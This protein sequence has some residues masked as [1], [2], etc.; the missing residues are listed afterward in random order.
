[1]KIGISGASGHLGKATVAELRRRAPEHQLVAISRTP[2]SETG[3]EARHGDYNDRAGLVAAYRGLDAVMLIPVPGGRGAQFR[4]AIDAAV[5]AGVGHILLLST[6]GTREAAEPSMFAAYWEGEQHLI[7]TAPRWTILRMNYYA[8]SFAQTAPMSAA[9]GALVGLGDGRVAFVSRDDVA[10]AAAGIL[11]GLGQ[12]GAIYNATG[13]TAYDGAARAAA[14]AQAAGK[15]VAFHVL[16]PAALREQLQAAQV[17][18]PYVAAMLDIE[19]KFAEGGFDL[20]S[21]DVLKLAGR[22]PRTLE[23]VLGQALRA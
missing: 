17:P 21:G 8:E 7:K 6:T 16:P 3:V 19:S 9:A 1:M 13:A 2:D 20:V 22:P 14:I 12:P 23:Q 11:L 15:P 5:E 10:A 18:A 4:N